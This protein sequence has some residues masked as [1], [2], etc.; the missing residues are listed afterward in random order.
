MPRPVPPPPP[1][2]SADETELAVAYLRRVVAVAVLFFTAWALLAYRPDSPLGAYGRK[3]SQ[4]WML[5]AARDID[6]AQLR[7]HPTGRVVWLVG[8]SILREGFDADLIN[9]QLES[10]QLPW[11]VAK[12]GQDRGATVLANGL[13]PHLPIREGDVVVHNV[14]AQNFRSDWL[15]W[16]DIPMVRLSRLLAPGE[17]W[18]LPELSLPD[19][20]EQASAVP[21][22]FWRWHDETRRGVTAWLTHLPFGQTPQLPKAGYHLRFHNYERGRAFRRGVPKREFAVNGLPDG[23]LDF[24]DAQVNAAALHDMRAFVARTGADLRLLEIPPSAFA[25]WRLQN[26]DHRA[27][28]DEWVMAQPE[29]VHAPQLPDADYY[30]RRH[31][32]FRGRAT[33][34]M[35]LVDWLASDLP[36]GERQRPPEDSVKIWPWP[37]P[38]PE[39]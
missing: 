34:S 22:G 7:A 19:R 37:G 24:T 1:Q 36:T 21:F 26:A 12:F 27:A 17:M 4:S 8:S 5:Q 29:R 13:L 15:A 31:P 25:Q 32:N 11:R 35:W 6:E 9:T 14:A 3:S 20:L 10:R 28:W 2:P 23:I 18:S 33:L 16:T 39:P 30:D 38:Q